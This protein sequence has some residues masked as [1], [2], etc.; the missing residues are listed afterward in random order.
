MIGTN[1]L[2]QLIL[3]LSSHGAALVLALGPQTTGKR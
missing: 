3:C 1:G 2:L